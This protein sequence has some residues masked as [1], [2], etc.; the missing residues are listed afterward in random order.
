MSSDKDEFC[1]CSFSPK[2]TESNVLSV[3]VAV[4]QLMLYRKFLSL[5]GNPTHN[6]PYSTAKIF[7]KGFTVLMLIV[8]LGIIIYGVIFT[9]RGTNENIALRKA[10]CDNKQLTRSSSENCKDVEKTQDIFNY[11]NI[12]NNAIGIVMFFVLLIYLLRA[13]NMTDKVSYILYTFL[14][15]ALSIGSALMKSNIISKL[16]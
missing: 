5:I 7:A 4:M 6:D 3:S 16:K 8:S 13:K 9:V 11:V 10:Y 14:F 2:Q 15:L 1:P 12:F